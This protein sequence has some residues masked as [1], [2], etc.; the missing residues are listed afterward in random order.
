MKFGEIKVEPKDVQDMV[1]SPLDQQLEE[2]YKYIFNQEIKKL[3][4]VYNNDHFA[5]YH[6]L[7]LKCD[8]SI[9]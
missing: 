8:V 7:I 2:I 5:D 6:T 4:I 9:K 1:I 3:G